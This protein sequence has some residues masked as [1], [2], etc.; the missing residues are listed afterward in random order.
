MTWAVIIKCHFADVWLSLMLWPAWGTCRHVSPRLASHNDWACACDGHASSLGPAQSSQSGPARSRSKVRSK[1]GQWKID[2]WLKL[3]QFPIMTLTER[4][5]KVIGARTRRHLSKLSMT[6][7][8]RANR[9]LSWSPAFLIG[10]FVRDTN[11]HYL[12]VRPAASAWPSTITNPWHEARI[13]MR[14]TLL[15]GQGRLS[16]PRYQQTQQAL[17]VIIV[18]CRLTA[19]RWT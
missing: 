10:Q 19:A 1:C 13:L 4:H 17:H 11:D 7:K 12:C 16:S 8:N 5:A 9:I 3:L 14:R 18:S 6:T 2:L 15:P